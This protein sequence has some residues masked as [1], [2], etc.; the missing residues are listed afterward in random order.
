MG[1][2]LRLTFLF[3]CLALPAAAQTI[4]SGERQTAVAAP[5]APVLAQRQMVAAA[6][7]LAAEA[8][9]AAN[10]GHGAA[11]MRFD[12]LV[13]AADGTTRRI[14]DAFRIGD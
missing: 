2:L 8:W 13:V 3:A 4:D 14:A 6:H 1:R 9:L 12:V 5:R 10:P 11:G 7:P